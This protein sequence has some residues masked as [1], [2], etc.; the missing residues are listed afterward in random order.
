VTAGRESARTT[1]QIHVEHRS[2]EISDAFRIE[3]A[4]RSESDIETCALN[5]LVIPVVAIA[6][7]NEANAPIGE[8]IGGF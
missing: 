2:L 5:P 6:G 7:H 3:R 1:N 8:Q 4:P